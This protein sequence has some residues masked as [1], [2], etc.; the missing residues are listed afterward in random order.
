MTGGQRV[1]EGKWGGE[2]CAF[3][4]DKSWQ[5]FVFKTDKNALM[6]FLINQIPDKTPSQLHTC[7][8]ENAS[9]GELAIYCLQGLNN[10][11]FYDLSPD[12]MKIQQAGTKKYKS[13][14][15]WIWSIQSS[16]SKTSELQNLWRK[17]LNKSN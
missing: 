6:E 2:G 9:K 15:A 10:V 14:Q 12:L 5:K 11:N 4:L 3:S 7:P 17:E 8:H 16:K 1:F 13:E